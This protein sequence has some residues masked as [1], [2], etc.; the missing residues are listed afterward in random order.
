MGW[1]EEISELGRGL[2]EAQDK[3]L[4]SSEHL[5][6]VEVAV[7]GLGESVATLKDRL[8]LMES[9]HNALFSENPLDPMGA[10]SELRQRVSHLEYLRDADVTAHEALRETVKEQTE[11]F[12]REIASHRN[13]LQSID[14]IGVT[15]DP[16]LDARKGQL[17]EIAV[18]LG[19][20]ED[21]L[22]FV[23]HELGPKAGPIDPDEKTAPSDEKMFRVR[24]RATGYQSAE[25]A[26]IEGFMNWLVAQPGYKER[27]CA[28]AS[29]YLT[30]P[31]FGPP[32]S[33][34]AKDLIVAADDF[35]ESRGLPRVAPELGDEP[36]PKDLNEVRAD[37]G[38]PPVGDPWTHR[39]EK[40]RCRT[41]MW[42]TEKVVKPMPPHVVPGESSSLR[43]LGRCRR[44]APTMSGYPVVYTTDWCGDHKLDE[45]KA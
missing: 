39:S 14:G 44:H 22:S 12:K 8:T 35:L 27:I 23:Q 36:H 4:S 30:I 25:S 3:L 34:S 37:F 2:E 26:M 20:L 33:S 19:S 5:S 7:T 31:G 9:R 32:Q 28:L 45:A 42:F 16:L 29:E 21:R 41:C 6:A 1:K 43:I 18:A 11:L 17:G 10:I 15:G 13:R 38:L 40:M 24:D